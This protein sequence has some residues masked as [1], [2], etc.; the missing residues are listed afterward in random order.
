MIYT[1]QAQHADIKAGIAAKVD[2]NDWPSVVASVTD[3]LT[4]ESMLK[5]LTPPVLVATPA[6]P[7]ATLAGGQQTVMVQGLPNR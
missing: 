1:Y 5:Q 3:L 4:L 6:P 2:A 7:A